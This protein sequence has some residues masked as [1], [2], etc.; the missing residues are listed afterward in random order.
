MLQVGKDPPVTK[1]AA[2]K[3]MTNDVPE[4]DECMINHAEITVGCAVVDVY[5]TEFE[6]IDLLSTRVALIRRN[7]GCS[8]MEAGFDSITHVR[9]FNILNTI[10]IPI[11]Q[12][13]HTLVAATPTSFRTHAPTHNTFSYRRLI[14]L[15][16]VALASISKQQNMELHHMELT[17]LVT[18]LDI[19][20]VQAES[21]AQS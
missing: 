17:C 2:T 19:F 16:I 20:P 18:V 14:C 12:L 8:T 10:H 7:D 11:T 21:T 6:V 5:G 4:I 1:T 3:K 13:Q 15:Q 9:Y